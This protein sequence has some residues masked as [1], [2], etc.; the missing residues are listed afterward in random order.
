M[1]VLVQPFLVTFYRLYL[2]GDSSRRTTTTTT[3]AIASFF[4][5]VLFCASKYQW[6]D[7]NTNQL[8]FMFNVWFE[9]EYAQWLAIVFEC[10]LYRQITDSCIVLQELVYS[11]FLIRTAT[12]P[13]DK[14]TVHWSACN[15][16][17]FQ[18]SHH[19]FDGLI[20]TTANTYLLVNIFRNGSTTHRY[21][22]YICTLWHAT[23]FIWIF[24][25]K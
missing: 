7:C 2:S 16:L 19:M 8:I 10:F 13:L 20:T 25:T 11:W 4:H 18:Y 24:K 15:T 1:E 9:L 3:L 22:D 21:E 5:K 6:N 23:Q 12:A 17:H 14:A